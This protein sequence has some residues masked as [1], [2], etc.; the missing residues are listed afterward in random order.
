MAL[1][2]QAVYK[3]ADD[4]AFVRELDGDS[5]MVSDKG[6]VR[7]GPAKS[8]SMSAIEFEALRPFMKNIADDR[9]E[10]A[11]AALVENESFS[12]IAERYGWKSRQAVDRIVSAVW[13]KYQDY[14][15]STRLVAELEGLPPGWQRV[16]ISAPKE[17]V[18]KILVQVEKARKKAQ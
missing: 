10:A 15:E 2:G 13:E 6:R 14:Q 4:G 16:T 17:L 1:A 5:S 18:D 3:G 12:V 8:R 11:R 7:T 9:L